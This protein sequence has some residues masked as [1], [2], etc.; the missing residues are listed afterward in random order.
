VDRIKVFF[1]KIKPLTTLSRPPE[2]REGHYSYM[3]DKKLMVY[4]GC[5]FIINKCYNNMFT[6]DMERNL[7]AWTEL[8]SFDTSMASPREGFLFITNK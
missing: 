8:T 3:L 7:M 6:L 2:A 1:A 4:G 5:D